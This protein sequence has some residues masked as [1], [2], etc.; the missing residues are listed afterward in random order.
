ML[1]TWVYSAIMSK[2]YQKY[3]AVNKLVSCGF[4]LIELSIVIVILGL[5]IGGIMSA[6]NQ[7]NRRSKQA[8]LK[9]KMDAV[10]KALGAFVKKNNRLP[11]PADGTYAITVA[12]F[13]KEGG[14]AGS[15]SCGDGATYDVTTGIRSADTTPPTANFKLSNTAIG[16]VP[17]RALGLPDEYALDPWGGRFTYA[18]DIRMTATSAFSSTYSSIDNSGNFTINDGLGNVRLSNAI[19]VVVSHGQNGHGAF[20]LA[21]GGTRKNAG[22][23]N[24]NELINCHCTNAGV[25]GT[26]SNI[27]VMGGSTA[28]SSSD[29]RTNFDDILRYY[30][31]GSFL[32]NSDAATEIK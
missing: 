19:A 14:T 5:M 17:V 27:Y 6:I 25:S 31:R 3:L 9:T 21:S 8:D 23:T 15:G 11:C 2:K 13:G 22:S 16:V 1:I 30:T 4:T 12:S 18:V 29:Q 20:Q 26:T 32:T 28:T 10:E 7:E 24:A